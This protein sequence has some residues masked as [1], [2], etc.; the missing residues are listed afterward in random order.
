MLT[1]QKKKTLNTT[2]TMLSSFLNIEDKKYKK[3]NL[4]VFKQ[5]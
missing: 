4:L 1:Q 2:N 3:Y 5:I